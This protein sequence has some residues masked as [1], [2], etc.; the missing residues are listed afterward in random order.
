MKKYQSHAIE[1]SGLTPAGKGFARVEGVDVTIPFALP[2]QQVQAYVHKKKRGQADARIEAVLRPRAD[3]ISP[4][5]PHFGQPPNESGRGC[6][7]CSWQQLPYEAQLDLKH[8]LIKKLLAPL[9]PEM[10]VPAPIA[11][12]QP[13]GYRNKVE[14]SFGDKIYIDEARYK[15]LREAGEPLP[16]GS[17]LGFHVPGSFGTVVDV[18]ECHLISKAALKVYQALRELLPTLGGEVYSPRHHTGFWRHLILRQGYR[19]NELMIHFNTTDSHQPNWQLAVDALQALDLDGVRIRSVLHSVH[20]GDA[21]IVGWN[22]PALLFGEALIEEELCGLRFEISPYAFFQTNTLAAEKL[23]EQIVTFSRL[24]RA[25]VVYDLY[26]GTGSIGMVLAKAG[27][28]RVYGLEEIESA[29]ADA[30]RNALANGLENCSFIAGKVEARLIELLEQDRPDL[31]VVDPPRAGLH[32]KVPPLLNRLRLPQLIYV[33]CNPAALAR[34]LEAL[35]PTY[36]VT[37]IQPVDLFPQT[38][39]IETVIRLEARPLE[40]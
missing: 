2:G 10:P 35:L 24:E 21:Q 40:A 28:S 15:A 34:D 38:G 6:G 23:Y 3:E 19:T 39:H 29:V 31:V 11:S 13:Y 1:V 27:A 36:R 7:G 8:D 18:R 16:T 32:P 5:C 30:G 22:K 4:R 26:S 37:A 20:T 14:L 33:S 17:F 12:P 25:P 9:L